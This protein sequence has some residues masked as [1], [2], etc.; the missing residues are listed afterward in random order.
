MTEKANQK[1]HYKNLFGA[2]QQPAW[3]STPPTSTAPAPPGP[4]LADAAARRVRLGG[5]RLGGGAGGADGTFGGGD[6]RWLGGWERRE[7]VVE[8]LTCVFGCGRER[9]EKGIILS[10]EEVV[11]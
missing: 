11:G 2:H 4:G 7:I 10:G 9:M 8:F 6:G 1:A 5:L 3:S